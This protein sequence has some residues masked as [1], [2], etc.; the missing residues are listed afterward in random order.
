MAAAT[1]I[2]GQQGG[3]TVVLATPEQEANGAGRQGQP[4]GD[5]GGATPLV[6]QAEDRLPKMAG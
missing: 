5:V 6:G 4:A 1:L 2:A 3:I